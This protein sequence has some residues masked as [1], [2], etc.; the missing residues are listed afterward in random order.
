MCVSPVPGEGFEPS[1]CLGKRP[2]TARVYRST[3][4]AFRS[5]KLCM[6]ITLALPILAWILG[7]VLYFLANP[8][9]QEIGRILFA[10]GMLATLL[11]FAGSGG[12]HIG[13]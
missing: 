5:Y 8:K 4:W 11:L 9:I 12:L 10:T 1:R 13:K 7:L 2:S 6:S 3:T